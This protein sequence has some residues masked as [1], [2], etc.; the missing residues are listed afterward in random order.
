MLLCF[1]LFTPL[2][3]AAPT[4]IFL[5]SSHNTAL[6]AQKVATDHVS[7]V[8]NNA[9]RTSVREVPHTP[10]PELEALVRQ[11]SAQYGVSA[12][13]M[14]RVINC[15]NRAW[16]TSIQSG[17]KYKPGNRWGLPAGSYERSYGLVQIHLPDNPHVSYEQAINA[18]FAITFMAQKFS[19]GRQRMW[20]CY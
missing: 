1:F 11:I 4:E 2:A 19:Q 8:K 17:H 3:A 14:I 16:N 18:E 20:S 7:T 6:K 12:N 13:E 5:P 9:P 10:K 15:E